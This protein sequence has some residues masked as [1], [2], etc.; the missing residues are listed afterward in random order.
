MRW[1]QWTEPPRFD[2]SVGRGDLITPIGVG[3]VI[4]GQSDFLLLPISSDASAYAACAS[5]FAY[6]LTSLHRLG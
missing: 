1:K 6:E 2:T 4:R 5:K 3:R